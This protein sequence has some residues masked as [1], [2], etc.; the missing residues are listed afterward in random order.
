[1]IKGWGWEVPQ[2]PPAGNFAF[3][4]ADASHILQYAVQD[5]CNGRTSVRLSVCLSRRS[6]AAPAAGRFAAERTA[7]RRLR[8]LCC[9]RR[10][11]TANA[12][13]VILRLRPDGG[14]STCSTQTCFS[15]MAFRTNYHW[16]ICLHTTSTEELPWKVF[17]CQSVVYHLLRFLILVTFWPHSVHRIGATDVAHSAFCVCLS[18]GHL[19]ELCRSGWTDHDAVRRKTAVGQLSQHVWFLIIGQAKATRVA[20]LFKVTHEG[21]APDGAESDVY[22]YFVCSWRNWAMTIY[23]RSLEPALNRETS[24]VSCNAAVAELCRWVSVALY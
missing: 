13:S 1:V 22:E 16:Y 3:A 5:L 10:R 20:P 12:G 4:Y 17:F 2:A 18:V 21:A 23:S 8:A 11:W 19:G 14:G 15:F 9:R 7:S 6:T 24:V